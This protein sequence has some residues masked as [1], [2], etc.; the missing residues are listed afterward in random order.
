MWYQN[1]FLF[2]QNKFVFEEKHFYYLTFFHPVKIPFYYMKFS[3][4]AFL[5]TI[6][7]LP[8]LFAKVRILLSLYKLNSSIML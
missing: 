5:A 7:G 3:F 1:I 6:S 2:N 8:I 4:N